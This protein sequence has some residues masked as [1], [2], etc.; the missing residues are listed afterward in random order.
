V[1][2][3]FSAQNLELNFMRLPLYTGGCSYDSCAPAFSLTGLC[4]VRYFRFDDDF[5]FGTEWGAPGSFDGWGNGPNELFHDV[6]MK[7]QLVGFQL[8][9]NMN[10]SVA[11]RWNV[12]WDSNFGIYN[13]HINHY[14]RMYNPINGPATFVEEGRDA[15]VISSKNDIAFLGEM[16]LG[17]GYLSTEHLRCVLAYRA[18]GIAGVALAPDQIKPYYANYADT[19]RIDADG[20]LIIHGIQAGFE[21]NY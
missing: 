16:R 19:A 12:F 15:T 20:S 14:Q 4:G 18:I 21:C 13:D 3:N 8:G 11:T 2:T 17:A 5:E 10:Y 9:A 6:Q 7:N 1:R